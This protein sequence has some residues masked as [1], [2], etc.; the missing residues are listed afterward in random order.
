MLD[1][2]AANGRWLLQ[3][4]GEQHPNFV[5]LLEEKLREVRENR[6]YYRVMSP[7]KQRKVPVALAAL[8]RTPE[9]PLLFLEGIARIVRY[10]V[11]HRLV[12]ITWPE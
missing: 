3:N 12:R 11:R 7:L 5:P 4:V 8:L 9:F 2:V 1:Q 6:R 10:R